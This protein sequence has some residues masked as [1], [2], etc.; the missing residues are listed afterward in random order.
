MALGDFR[1]L[2]RMNKILVTGGCGYIGS[3]TLVDLIE[4]GFNVISVD[5]N[6]RSNPKIL[7]G[8]ERITGVKVKNY[9]VDLC[10]FDDTHAIFQENPDIT[11]IIHFAAYKSVG[12]SVENPL[13]Y[14]ENNLNS[15][16]NILKCAKEFNIP[17]FIFSSSCTVYGNPTEIPV[18]ESTPMQPPQSPYGSTKQMGEKILKQ[19]VHY[20]A[21][22]QAVI[23][24]YFNPVGAHTSGHIGELPI[25]RPANLV[26]A[27]TQ[28]AIGKLT[29]MQ[30]Y[31]NDY[32]TKDGSCIR[33][34]I[35]V[36]DIAHA[37]TLALN[38]LTN[39]KNKTNCDIFNLGSGNGFT[40]LEVI[41]A[42]EK[43]SGKSL[44]Y[45]MSER[46]PGDVVAIFANNDTAKKL[47]GWTPL[48]ELEEMMQTAWKWELKLQQDENL[49]G[50]KN[51]VLN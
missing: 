23:L 39:K 10:I 9:T 5:N 1:F 3:H 16:I 22:L 28:T 24:R 49:F 15:L 4:N 44:N 47:L 45:T 8:I 12:E 34:Y 40:V 46:R 21:G 14:Y 31:G 42:F 27:I 48:F 2:C 50:G 43:I 19:I 29:V 20:D 51:V 41:K 33:D 30:V 32:P 37:H 13:L 25:G 11:G 35:H 17:H 26:P 18:T 6:S 36:S 38:Y 7:E